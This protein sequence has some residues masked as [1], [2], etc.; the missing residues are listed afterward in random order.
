MS[1]NQTKEYFK[2]YYKDNKK[3]KCILCSTK[4]MN[5]RCYN[6]HLKTNKHKINFQKIL[7]I[8]IEPNYKPIRPL[9]PLQ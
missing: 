2:K 8:I 9:Q 4:K 3:Y 1:K 6:E 7:D 5:K